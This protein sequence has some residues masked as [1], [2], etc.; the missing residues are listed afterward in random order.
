MPALGELRARGRF[1]DRPEP[2]LIDLL[3]IVALETVMSLARRI[4]ADPS[5]SLR[6]QAHLGGG[7]VR[8]LTG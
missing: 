5:L 6:A 7:E 4:A 2:K 3:D 1:A 8:T